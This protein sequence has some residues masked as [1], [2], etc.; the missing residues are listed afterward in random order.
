ML[1]ELEHITNS[2]TYVQGK[3][4]GKYQ[5]EKGA[6]TYAM[7][8]QDCHIKKFRFYFVNMVSQ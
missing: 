8:G 7:K 1:R 2:G 5:D 4:L 6:K 3:G